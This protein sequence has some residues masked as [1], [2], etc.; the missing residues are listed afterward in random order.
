[1]QSYEIHELP[2]MPKEWTQLPFFAYRGCSSCLV[3]PFDKRATNK[4]QKLASFLRDLLDASCKLKNEH[5]TNTPTMSNINN[6]FTD[7]P[8]NNQISIES[9]HPQSMRLLEH[10]QQGNSV[11]FVQAREMGITHLDRHIAELRRE[12]TIHSRVI[13]MGNTRCLEYSLHPLG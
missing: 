7:P 6:P 3:L 13:R 1:M 4:P 11:N 10:L 2:G 8:V 12:L 9:L 5:K